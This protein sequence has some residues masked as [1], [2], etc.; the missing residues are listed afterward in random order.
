MQ[1]NIVVES[2]AWNMA[3]L[4]DDRIHVNW[5]DEIDFDVLDYQVRNEMN[6]I[7]FQTENEDDAISWL[8][9]NE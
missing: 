8:K 3:S 2:K 4:K 5:S 6:Q 9:A 7:V 1:Y